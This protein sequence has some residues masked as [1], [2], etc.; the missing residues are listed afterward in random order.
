V[1]AGL[2]CG[3]VCCAGGFA[4]RAGLEPAPTWAFPAIPECRKWSLHDLIPAY[5]FSFPS[6]IREAGASGAR[7]PTWTLGTSAKLRRSGM[8]LGNPGSMDG[9]ALRHPRNLD[10][11]DPCRNDG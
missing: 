3:R 4:V 11:G 2:M 10:S 6:Q 8:E 1:W 5:D 9:A 7:F